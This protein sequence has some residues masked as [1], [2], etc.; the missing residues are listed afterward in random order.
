MTF[1]RNLIAIALILS[2][3]TIISCGK[4]D[5]HTTTNPYL[6]PE[7]FDP[8]ATFYVDRGQITLFGKVLLVRD[9]QQKPNLKSYKIQAC[10]KDKALMGAVQFQ[11]FKIKAGGNEIVKQTDI[12]GC[13][14][15]DEQLRY[16][17]FADEA[18]LQVT[19]TIEAVRGHVGSVTIPLSLNPWATEDSITI[20]DLRFE[21]ALRANTTQNAVSYTLSQFQSRETNSTVPMFAMEVA[22]ASAAKNNS[23]GAPASTT[24]TRMR[25]DAINLQFLG[26]D[27]EQYEITSTLNL[28]VAHKYR[29]RI[30][31]QFIRTNFNGKQ[32]FETITSGNVKFNVA[33]LRDTVSTKPG[34]TTY[35]PTDVLATTEFVGE[36]VDGV[37]VADMTLKFQDL[38]PLTGR[39]ILIMSSS[40]MPGFIQFREA[41]Y[42]SPVGPI[43]S[44]SSI[45]FVPS[46]MNAEKI[47]KNHLD[48]LAKKENRAKQISNFDFFK[49]TTGFVEVAKEISTDFGPRLVKTSSHISEMLQALEKDKDTLSAAT[50]FAICSQLTGGY[51]ICN[52]K[53]LD[54]VNIRS[55]DIVDEITNPVPRREGVTFNEDLT[56]NANYAQTSDRTVGKG[57][58]FKLGLTAGL[59]AGLDLSILDLIGGKIPI[60]H[61]V[62]GFLSKKVGNNTPGGKP[63]EPPGFE[64][65]KSAFGIKLGGTATYNQDLYTWAVTEAKKDTGSIS[66]SV[67]FAANAEMKRFKFDGKFTKCWL[68]NL[69]TPLKEKLEKQEGKEFAQLGLPNGVYLCSPKSVAGTRTEMFVLV[70]SITGIANSPLTDPLDSSEAPL[71]MSFRSP[72][73]YSIFKTLLVE[74]KM[75]LSFDKF[76]AGELIKEVQDLKNEGDVFL[77]QEFPG[78]LNP[79]LE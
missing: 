12:L 78:I 18:E 33:V 2:Q 65:P 76:P 28:K 64:S 32:I 17:P 13:L 30:S 75:E 3:F 4:R 22:L 45:S 38:A 68:A 69:S 37:M 47:H 16:D 19:R 71:R 48:Y 20:A 55:R 21:Q 63:G 26:H 44:A 54:L 66:T 62:L 77:N 51:K 41:N 24:G 39:T 58:N 57:K 34:N 43:V 53:N 23:C 25:L 74:N 1:S 36:M 72:I 61:S 29:V 5:D 14:I 79:I 40:S 35:K 11:D 7:A 60:L 31:P 9:A 73:G 10:L 27:Y 8:N 46:C 42:I 52:G 6:A 49:K 67:K 56:I 70:N 59:N 15:W 50:R